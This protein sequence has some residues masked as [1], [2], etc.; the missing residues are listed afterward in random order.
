MGLILLSLDMGGTEVGVGPVGPGAGRELMLLAIGRCVLW[1]TLL[2]WGL[3]GSL[4]G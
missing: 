1:A 3:C 2:G 4:A